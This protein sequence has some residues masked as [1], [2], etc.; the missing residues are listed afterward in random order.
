MPIGKA[1]Q[2]IDLIRQIAPNV[3]TTEAPRLAPILINQNNQEPWYLSKVTWG[4]VA[5]ILGGLGTHG[6]A[7]L[8]R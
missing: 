5:A 7:V 3:T 1:V 6:R 8:V 4:A 2:A